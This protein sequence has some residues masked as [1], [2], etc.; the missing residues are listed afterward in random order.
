MSTKDDSEFLENLPPDEKSMSVEYTPKHLDISAKTHSSVSKRNSESE[1]FDDPE[2]FEPGF[3][4]LLG[5]KRPLGL[6]DIDIPPKK[7][8]K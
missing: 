2:F 5:F 8:K 3:K 1:E 7:K 4:R 6:P